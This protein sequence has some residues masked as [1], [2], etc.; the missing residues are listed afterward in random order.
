[1]PN[2]IFRTFIAIE[3]PD[4]VKKIAAEIQNDLKQRFKCRVAW[5]KPHSM[6]LT[7]KFLGDTAVEKIEPIGRAL[8][9]TLTGFGKF[10]MSLS[11]PGTFGGRDPK[12]AWLGLRAPDD[13]QA[14]HTYVDRV[15]SQFGY[16]H[17]RRNFH[18]HL[19]L[20]RIKDTHGTREMA[21]YIKQIEVEPVLFTVNKIVHFKS[22]LRPGGAAYTVLQEIPLS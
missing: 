15:I 5:I 18:P 19:T 11:K 3:T 10:K 7:L 8:N 14:L 2:Q 9:D 21:E 20:G 17:E 13:L 4:E 1:M 12:V 16:E 6:H 22:D